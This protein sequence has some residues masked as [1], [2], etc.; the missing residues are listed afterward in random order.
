VHKE[1]EKPEN[2]L[3][4]ELRHA[5]VDGDCDRLVYFTKRVASG[6]PYR[7]IDLVD[8]DKQFALIIIWIHKRLEALDL[9]NVVTHAII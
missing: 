3:G 9:E 7:A 5:S 2:M 1:H 4:L 8:G 6:Y